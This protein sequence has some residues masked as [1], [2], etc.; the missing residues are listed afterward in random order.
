MKILVPTDFSKTADKAFQYAIDC[1][2]KSDTTYILYHSFMPFESGFYSSQ[3]SQEENNR[4]EDE[5]GIRLKQ[6]ADKFAAVNK[7]VDIKIYVDR[8]IEERSIINY[9]RNIKAELIVMGTTGA[10]GLKEKL[11]GSVT[12]NIMSKSDCP[13]IG[14]PEKYKPR[15]LKELAFCSNYQLRDIGALKYL[16]NLTKKFKANI[17]IWHFHKMEDNA[18]SENKLAAD[19]KAMV[20]KIFGNKKIT[21]QF[22][23]TDNIQN[24]LDKLSARKDL[25]MIALI[26]HRRKGFFNSLLDKSLTKKVA[27]HTKVPLLVI[28]SEEN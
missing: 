23:H 22:S 8:G 24:A 21:F 3:K 4:A 14:I 9:A 20:R 26:T 13:V 17:R 16:F 11:I 27:Y 15:I 1:F 25:D 12:A 5:L 19:Y 10:T 6:K 28:P 18:D 2:N 7:N